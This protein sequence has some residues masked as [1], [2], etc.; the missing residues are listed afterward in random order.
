MNKCLKKFFSLAFC[1]QL[2]FNCVPVSQ[3]YALDNEEL[4]STLVLRKPD[5]SSLSNKKVSKAQASI[6]SS[7]DET[8]KTQT[9]KKKVSREPS[10]C[11]RFLSGLFNVS[12]EG[13]RNRSFVTKVVFLLASPLAVMAQGGHCPQT[14]GGTGY[15]RLSSSYSYLADCPYSCSGQVA[16]FPQ[17]L[18][19]Q[20]PFRVDNI[21]GHLIA[22][23]SSN[24]Q[25]RYDESQRSIARATETVSTLERQLV[26]ARRD[27]EIENQKAKMVEQDAATASSSSLSC[28]QPKGMNNKLPLPGSASESCE[29]TTVVEFSNTCDYTTQCK[30]LNGTKKRN[31]VSIHKGAP[32][33][34][35]DGTSTQRQ[36]NCDGQ[37]KPRN[38]W[39]SDTQCQY[40]ATAERQG[41]DEL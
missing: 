23:C 25:T 32:D 1:V 22:S 2:I 18:A 13:F 3:C 29:D 26:Q 12:A 4:S 10:W 20:Y 7:N 36:E 35:V 39:E 17:S 9:P 19:S 30:R 41:K 14:L 33:C 15:C 40:K 27:L 31:K 5:T 38:S 34:R 11:D 37:L 8:S 24:L 28:P 21:A 16:T 6:S